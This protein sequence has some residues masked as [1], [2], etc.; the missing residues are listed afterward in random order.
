MG[1]IDELLTCQRGNEF[2]RYDILEQWIGMT[3][4]ELLDTLRKEFNAILVGVHPR[5]EDQVIVNP[6]EYTFK[7]GDQIV[8]I[9]EEELELE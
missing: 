7:Q 3:F 4:D 8:A 1:V 5:D 6:V 9:S 2:Y